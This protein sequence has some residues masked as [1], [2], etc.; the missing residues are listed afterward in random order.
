VE[1]D[2]D[3]DV[4]A[5]LTSFVEQTNDIVGVGDPWGRILYL[6]PAACKRLGVADY[7]DLT[8][9]DLFPAE[10]FAYYYEIVRPELLRYGAWSGEVLVNAAGSGAVPMH[11]STTAQLGP[12]GETNGGVVLARDLPD[13]AP[14]AL[15]GEGETLGRVLDWSAFEE[16]VGAALAETTRGGIGC[17]LVL[18]TVAMHDTIERYGTPSTATVLR[19]LAAR[20]SRVA[21]SIDAVGV[22]DAQ[23]Q[24]GLLL[25][26][27]R[28]HGEALRIASDVYA[29]LVDVPVTSPS[30]LIAPPVELGVAFSNGVDDAGALFGRASTTIWPTEAF[31]APRAD[32]APDAPTIEEFRVGMSH[33]EVRAYAQPVV[34]VVSD[35]VI[36]YRAM[37]RWQHPRLGLLEPAVFLPLIAES[38]LAAEVDLYVTR[39]AAAALTVVAR[40]NTRLRLYFPVSKRLVADVRTEQYLW[41]IADAFSLRLQ[42][43]CLQVDRPL[44]EEWTPALQDALQ[45]LGDAGVTLVVTGIEDAAD[46]PAIAALGFGELHVGGALARAAS[47]DRGAQRMVADIARAAHDRSLLV[48]ATGV[49][50]S[51]YRDAL[52]PTG[53]DLATGDLYG[54]A[55]PTDAIE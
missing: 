41:E 40:E 42:H 5:K 14:V 44:L 21:R 9:A 15:A 53:I 6:N 49:N 43:L 33:G 10:A 26:G 7:S 20:M 2:F 36:G 18:A 46:V 45:S 28:N 55:R 27:V 1:S 13:S 31:T 25:R 37:A 11:I 54:E 4:V 29:S 38:I 32:V 35:V 19:T 12:G 16:Q 3:A 48:G 50:A 30:G 22:R 47:S 51:R 52:I 23:Y 24:L 34:E 8:L 17:A 39:E